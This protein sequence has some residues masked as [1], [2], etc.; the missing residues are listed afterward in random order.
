[1]TYAA[2]E[3]SK[4]LLDPRWQRVRLEIF[5]R[6]NFTCQRCFSGHKTL[7]IHH[8]YYNRD[9]DPWEYPLEALVC[10]CD[11]CHQEE[12]DYKETEAQMLRD[13][14]MAGLYGD[15]FFTI[16]KMF[17][18]CKQEEQ[19]LG[20]FLIALSSFLSRKEYRDF[21]VK[22]F[23]VEISAINQASKGLK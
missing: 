11:T 19:R 22:I 16:G 14:K 23:D 21:I 5:N 2:S 4:K 17:L 18:D 15:D 7:H 20:Y 9:L 8:H 12:H 1:M 6:D 10:L 3:Y 13:M